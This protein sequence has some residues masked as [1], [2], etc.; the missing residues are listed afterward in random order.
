MGYLFLQ[1]FSSTHRSLRLSQ[2]I[3]GVGIVWLIQCLF[4]WGRRYTPCP[5][6]GRSCSFKSVCLLLYIVYHTSHSMSNIGRVSFVFQNDCES[7]WLTLC[8]NKREW[9][10]LTLCLLVK[11][12]SNLEL[13]PGSGESHVG[14][15]WWWNAMYETKSGIRPLISITVDNLW[16][17]LVGLF[18]GDLALRKI[19]NH[20]LYFV[21]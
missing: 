7:R 15:C 5:T 18:L 19:Q 14:I 6:D 12:R 4:I 1:I 17:M 3:H 8:Y 21:D 10:D 2:M 11:G 16:D 13:C 20:I 9:C